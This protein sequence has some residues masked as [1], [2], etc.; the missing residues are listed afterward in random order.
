MAASRMSDPAS[1]LCVPSPGQRLDM[2][3]RCCGGRDVELV[4]DLGDQPHCN[5]LVRG[6]LAVGTEPFYP[7]RLG[8]CRHCTMVQ[9]DHTIPKETMFSD[10][11]YVSGTTQTLPEHFRR[12]SERLASAYGLG[13]DALVVDIG[14][15]DGTWLKQ[16]APFGCRVLG[17]EAAHNVAR[18]A[19]E[20]GVP[21][22]H[23]FFNEQC[24]SDIR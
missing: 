2:A 20:A 19:N 13:S 17:I 23:C 14:S 10:Y 18:L 24:A 22:W 4:I 12:T 8:F 21:T 3:C 16:Y 5:R 9:I 15:N 6:D 7:L 11:P 1:R